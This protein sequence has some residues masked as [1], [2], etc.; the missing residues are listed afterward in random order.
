M[1]IHTNTEYEKKSV[2][3]E[4]SEHDYSRGYNDKN[5]IVFMD[6]DTLIAAER[7]QCIAWNIKTGTQLWKQDIRM[8]CYN[9]AVATQ[10]ADMF[11]YSD[12]NYSL[13]ICN[14]KTGEVF[15]MFKRNEEHQRYNIIDLAFEPNSSTF[16][17]G[18]GDG[19][20]T[21][22]DA[23]GQYEPYTIRDI[24]A[25]ISLT[26]SPDG[27]IIAM[28]NGEGTVKVF[29]L[30]TQVVLNTYET[31]KYSSRVR[32]WI[33]IGSLI[34]F[35]I[36]TIAYRPNGGRIT[37][38][39]L[40]IGTND[41]NITIWESICLRGETRK[42]HTLS[43]HTKGIVSLAWGPY[44]TILAS[45]Q[46]TNENIRLWNADNGENFAI[47]QGTSFVDS[48]SFSPDGRTLASIDFLGTVTVWERAD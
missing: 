33:G 2:L 8:G 9:I 17:I 45:A 47:L 40:A 13:N 12:G 11:V 22:M 19:T 46:R 32:Y 44:G 25:V 26:W 16:A 18:N 10:Y 31:V 4:H 28:A 34:P 43:G 38:G 7:Y 39:H 5:H 42:L 20:I 30:Y 41:G 6:N 48:L 21:F 1:A 27:K 29:N 36:N 23:F 35:R 15:Q 37:A 14:S 3:T 24:G